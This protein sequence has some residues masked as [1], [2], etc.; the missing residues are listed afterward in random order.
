MG[1]NQLRPIGIDLSTEGW[2]SFLATGVDQTNDGHWAGRVSFVASGD[3]DFDGSVEAI[4][5]IDASR[6]LRPRQI[7]CIDVSSMTVKW[8][9][10]WPSRTVRSQ[11]A[12]VGDSI[13]NIQPLCARCNSKKTN[14]HIDYR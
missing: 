2:T 3:F 13:D 9:L 12:L 7:V 1:I 14:K 8:N 5:S 4:L 10:M 6:D 11:F